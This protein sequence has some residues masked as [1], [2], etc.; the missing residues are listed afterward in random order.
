MD[1]ASRKMGAFVGLQLKAPTG[2]RIEQ[3]KRLDFLASN[4]EAKYDAILADIDLANFVS[5]EKIIIHSD[6]QL[7]VG[8]VNGEYKT[9]DQRMAK[10]VCL[11]KLRL[12]RFTA[13]KLEHILMGSNE[14]VGALVAVAASLPT[15]EI[16]LLP[17]Y[18]QSGSSIAA[19]QVN[20]IDEA[21]PSW[22]T[23]IIRYMS[24][25]ELPDSK[26]KSHKIQV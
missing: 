11:V 16:M 8:Q 6:S 23:P 4:N 20:D 18:Y 22:M 15:K 25:G 10:Y 13:W 9:R 3:A 26:V 2:E 14:K 5:S 12:D 21:C 1:G 19:N 7:V 24:L 17:V